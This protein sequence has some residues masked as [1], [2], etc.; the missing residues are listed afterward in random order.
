MH[1]VIITL[2]TCCVVYGLVSWS[3]PLFWKAQLPSTPPKPVEAKQKEEVKKERLYEAIPQQGEHIGTLTFPSLD[4][5]MPIFQGSHEN[6]LSKGAGHYH[7]SALPG[8]LDNV[9]IGGH[10]DT[11]FLKLGDLKKDDNIEIETSAG[12][13]VYKVTN[14]KVV[15]KDDRTIIVSTYPEPKLT[16][17]TCY[18]FGFIGPA[19]DRYIVE[20]TLVESHTKGG[21]SK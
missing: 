20:A 6:E 15:E 1:R 2:G 18:P 3:L 10:R 13:F 7:K 4:A 9:V 19:P 17:V 12:R 21:K 11:V 14:T 5:E 8:E 16:L